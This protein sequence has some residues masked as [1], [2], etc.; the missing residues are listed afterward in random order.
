MARAS[1]DPLSAFERGDLELASEL[2]R[3]QLAAGADAPRLNHLLGLIDCRSGKFE[4]GVEWLRRACEADPT[5]VGY[6]V[7][8]V[9]ALIDC[10]LNEEAL[11]EAP[12]PT[13]TTPAELALWHARAEAATAVE[14]WPEAAE[15]WGKM[16]AVR[17][18]DWRTWS[19]FGDALGA[20]G[21]WPEAARALEKATALHP[22]EPRL[23]RNLAG[24]LNN[25]GRSEESVEQFRRCIAADPADKSLRI[26]L[27]PILA[28]LGR[29]EESLEQLNKAAEL[30]GQSELPTDG[31]GL[32]QM[33]IDRSGTVDVN[34]LIEL[35]ELLERT[36]RMDALS[37]LIE[38]AGKIGIRP[39]R[40]GYAAAASALRDGRPAQAKRL[41]LG[42]NEAAARP[43]AWH[44]LMARTEDALGN[45]EAAFASAEAMNR[46]MAGYAD[47]RRAAAEQ[48]QY[49]RRLGEVISAEWAAPLR[50]PKTEI[51]S[52]QA[53]VVGFPR[54][55]TTLLDTF[56]MGH[57]DA[58][59]LEEVPLIAELERVLGPLPNLPGCPQAQLDEAHGAYLHKRSSHLEP[60][61][62]GIV[63]DKL[64]LNMVAAPMLHCAFPQAP[65]IFAKRHPCDVVLSCFMQAFA[66][67]PMMASF[68]DI[69]DA[70]DF[71]DAAMTVWTKSLQHLPLKVHTVVYEELVEEPQAALL[72]A[73]QF[74]GLDWRPQ[75][76]DHQKTAKRRGRIDTPSYDQVTQP[77]TRSASGR[78][79]RYREQLEPVL[80]VLLPWA[81]RL[82]YED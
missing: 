50:Q 47:W 19:H 82:G 78:W 10:G 14:A 79:K 31:A 26:S 71:Y 37:G 28:D 42:Q 68:L 1:E 61:F 60:G 66:L 54:S 58:A 35:A 16:C 15:A 8:L 80:P 44:R 39:E 67:T 25:A 76:L 12:P 65:I 69:R 43:T 55:G 52:D 17:S 59:V 5:N 32:V 62:S 81:R 74:I 46:S 30:S 13:G 57:P 9:R 6:R 56:L 22:R 36:S 41:L 70:A 72:A 64:P 2:A 23:Q 7:M 11:K 29:A 34:S 33:V 63:I 45:S 49:L 40:I 18:G 4:T 51:R 21:R 48:R 38:E 73:T 20:I 77:L 27:A 53:F 24:A 3:Q 75:L